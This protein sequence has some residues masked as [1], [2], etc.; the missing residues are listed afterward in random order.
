ME[1]TKKK[2]CL[3][4]VVRLQYVGTEVFPQT[5]WNEWLECQLQKGKKLSD[6]RIM[7][8]DGIYKRR[9]LRI[10]KKKLHT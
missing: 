4:E 10:E 1:K 7:V 5:V 8:G 3:A 6:N 2:F 9:S